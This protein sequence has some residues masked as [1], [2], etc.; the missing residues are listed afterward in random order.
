MC[1]RDRIDGTYTVIVTDVCGRI[2]SEAAL[3][4]IDCLVIIPNVFSPNNDG[5]NDRWEIEGLGSRNTVKVFN[6]WGNVVLDAKNYRN[7]WAASDAVSY[8]HLTLPT[9]DLV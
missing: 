6:R 2:G 3:V 8:T 4:T 1:R 7:N 9:S 5:Y